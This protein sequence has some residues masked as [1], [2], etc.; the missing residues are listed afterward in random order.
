[1]DRDLP[2]DVAKMIAEGDFC[3]IIRGPMVDIM[4]AFQ[5]KS[6]KGKAVSVLVYSYF[7]DP[8]DECS[9]G[10]EGYADQFQH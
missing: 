4:P 2:P 1:M 5:P 7:P 6:R 10:F 8:V 9:T 3:P